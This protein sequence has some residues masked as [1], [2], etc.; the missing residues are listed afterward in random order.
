MRHR[1]LL[2]LTPRPMTYE[3]ILLEMQAACRE[4]RLERY[5]VNHLSHLG[6]YAQAEHAAFLAR[7][8]QA[9]VFPMRNSILSAETGLPTVTHHLYRAA[10]RRQDWADAMRWMR[11][12]LPPPEADDDTNGYPAEVQPILP[13][14][15]ATVL[16]GAFAHIVL[17]LRKRDWHEARL[18]LDVFTHR[19]TRHHAQTLALE[20]ADLNDA[21]GPHD[22]GRT[23]LQ[24][25]NR[26]VQPF[27][28]REPNPRPESCHLLMD[29]GG[30]LRDGTAL[31]P[32][33][34]HAALCATHRRAAHTRLGA[35]PPPILQAILR[36]ARWSKRKQQSCE[37][38]I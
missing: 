12:H 8:L 9:E 22:A 38:N 33:L 7:E 15:Y 20:H 30:H 29:L 6:T 4:Q 3:D 32:A 2:E 13:H 36:W 21:G 35:L 26:L 24:D 27:L 18:R 19:R 16:R 17:F 11:L 25:W 10:L 23:P 28:D 37:F 5:E 31:H 34:F 1:R 14:A